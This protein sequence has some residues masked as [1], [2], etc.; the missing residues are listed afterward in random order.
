[1]APYA[2]RD[3][4]ERMLARRVLAAVDRYGVGRLVHS[5]PGVEVGVWEPLAPVADADPR[6]DVL[7]G[8]VRGRRWR[9]FSV[10]GVCT[11]LLAVLDAWQAENES[12]DSALRRLLDD[13]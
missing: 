11:H 1:M 5:V 9:G 6:V 3:M 7:A 2:W 12:F 4:T 8:S 10:E 13:R